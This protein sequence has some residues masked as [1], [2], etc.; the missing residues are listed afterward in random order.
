ML[1]KPEKYEVSGLTLREAKQVAYWLM[2]RNISHKFNARARELS[3]IKL[4]KKDLV[5]FQKYFSGIDLKKSE[6]PAL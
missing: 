5:H 2:D 1:L 4:G 6:K 3:H